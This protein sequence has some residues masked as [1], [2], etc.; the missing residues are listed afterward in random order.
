[1]CI[2][3]KKRY[4]LTT[5]QLCPNNVSIA[6]LSPSPRSG[7]KLQMAFCYHVSSVF[8]NPEQF[9]CFIFLDLFVL[10]GIGQLLCWISLH[11]GLSD[12]STWLDSSYACWAGVPWSEVSIPAST[13]CGDCPSAGD[14]R[15]RHLLEVTFT[16]FSCEI[17]VFPLVINK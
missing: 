15:F 1:M 9:L 3:L 17:T 5:I 11:L 4:T 7:S 14:G 16:S 6:L 13:G 12:G 10:N 2:S 8:F